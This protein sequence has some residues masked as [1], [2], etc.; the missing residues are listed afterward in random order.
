MIAGVFDQIV[1]L[2][3]LKDE[4]NSI[5]SKTMVI[6]RLSEISDPTPIFVTTVRVRNASILLSL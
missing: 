5:A 1:C 4:Q 6:R 2:F 3:P